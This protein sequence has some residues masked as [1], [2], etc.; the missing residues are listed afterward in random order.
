MEKLEAAFSEAVLQNFTFAQTQFGSPCMQS[1][2][3]VELYG[4]LSMAKDLIGRKRKSENFDYLAERGALQYSLEALCVESRFGALFT[5][6]EVNHC[7]QLLCDAG[8]FIKFL[9]K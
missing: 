5:D 1:I 8:Y 9:R 7:L 3:Q 4:A 2:R 6:E